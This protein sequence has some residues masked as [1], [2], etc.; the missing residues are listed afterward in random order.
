[1]VLVFGKHAEKTPA[2]TRVE[3]VPAKTRREPIKRGMANQGVRPGGAPMKRQVKIRR[4]W[5][6]HAYVGPNGHG[7]SLCAV[8]DSM[9]SLERG[10]LVLSTVPLL[11]W[12]AV[13][14]P[15]LYILDPVSCLYVDESG[16]AWKRPEHRN[17]RRLTEWKQLMEFERGDVLLDDVA[18][19]ASSRQSSGMPAAIEKLLQKLRHDDIVLRWT[20]PSWSR[21]DIVIRETTQAVTVAEGSRPD[22]TEDDDRLW[23]R[24]R[25]FEWTTYDAKLFTDWSEGKIEKAK[26]LSFQ[27]FYAPGSDAFKAYDSLGGVDTITSVTDAGR[28]VDCGGTRRAPAC[29]C[30]EYVA[31]MDESGSGRGRTARKRSADGPHLAPIGSHHSH[32][33]SEDVGGVR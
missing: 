10:R 13:P 28:C 24:N 22:R 9:P 27:R 6:I 14:D 17:Y 33:H 29:T 31:R 21:A 12:N 8:I 25:Q 20:A 26:R 18:G 2:V 19:V 15:S 23:R 7:K 30:H 1:M 5:P 16:L 11:D 3:I 4:G 32:A